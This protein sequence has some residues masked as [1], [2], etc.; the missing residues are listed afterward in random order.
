MKKC[1]LLMTAAAIT[2]FSFAQAKEKPNILL[3]IADDLGPQLGCYGDANA[4]SPNIDKLA[5]QGVRFTQAH[6]TAASCSPSRGS[7][8]TGLYP[9]QHGMYSLSQQ[10]WAKMHDDVPKLPNAMNALGYR[11]AIIGKTHYEPEHLFEWD[12]RDEN[13]Q[14]VM[15][16]RDVRWMNAQADQWLDGSPQDKPFLLCMSYVDPH[17]GG[18]DGRYGAEYNEKFPRVRVGLPEKPLPPDD[19]VP[20]PFLAVNSPEVRMENSDYYSCI[21]RLDTGVGELLEML[22]AKD[23][24]DNTLI[25]LIGD[26]GPDLTRGKI[27][28]YATATHI[29]MLVKWPGHAQAGL[30]RDELV[31]TIDLFPTF[32][33]AAGGKI[34][35]E[36]QTGRPLQPLMK[37]GLSTWREWLGTEFIAH[38]PW[39]YYPRYAMQNGRYQLVINLASA[40]LENPLEGHN[41]CY[42]WHEVMKPQYEGTQLRT[43]YDAVERPPVVELFDKQSDPFL[44]NN[45]AVNPEYKQTVQEF[46]QQIQSWREATDDPF[47]DPAYGRAYEEHVAQ[48]KIDWEIRNGIRKAAPPKKAKRDFPQVGK[49]IGFTETFDGKISKVWKSPNGHPGQATRD[50]VTVD[51]SKNGFSMTRQFD[52]QGLG[53]GRVE[54]SA[55]FVQSGAAVPHSINWNVGISSENSKY[56]QNM[57]A[58]TVCVRFITAGPNKGRL[59]WSVFCDGELVCKSWSDHVFKRWNPGDEIEVSVSYDLDSGEAVAKAEDLTRGQVL[60][61]DRVSCPGLVGLRYSGFEMTLFPEKMTGPAGLVKRFSFHAEP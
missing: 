4:V 51:M 40:E 32:V 45:L 50:G 59:W 20:V 52:G 24:L 33:T 39:H 27:S 10:G 21:Q 35:D 31:S 14:K 26:H 61:E 28:A 48:Q 13:A 23:A 16:D 22:D 56:I 57:N 19:T 60:A 18:G 46:E 42:A 15:I 58:D 25:V 30:V 2:V 11:T 54:A 29:P 34:T 36:R 7:I 47:L 9:H 43:A 49:K 3:I 44:L 6:V 41:Y 5:E 1:S 53:A 37:S 17:R 8:M 12:L 38:V 55:V